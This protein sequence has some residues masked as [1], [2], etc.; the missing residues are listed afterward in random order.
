MVFIIT[1][2]SLQIQTR[3]V[4]SFLNSIEQTLKIEKVFF[5]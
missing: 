1:L 3:D 5:V 2:V 4:W